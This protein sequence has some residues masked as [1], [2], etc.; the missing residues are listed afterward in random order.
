MIEKTGVSPSCGHD[1]HGV[2]LAEKVEP[3][4]PQEIIKATSE[5]SEPP[6]ASETK[7]L[8]GS[9]KLMTT[10][11]RLIGHVGVDVYL[12]WAKAASGLWVP[13]AIVLVYGAVEVI[14]VAS[15]WWLTYW[16]QHG[17]DENQMSFLG[18]YALINL[19]NVLSIFFRI[20]FVMLLGLRASR[21]VCQNANSL[22]PA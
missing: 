4:D 13:F 1:H 8:K 14:S 7:D 12:Y 6:L 3:H 15:K 16:S 11:E 21:Q 17:S 22:L 18:V 9:Q 2:V 20:I 10:E 5:D 19:V